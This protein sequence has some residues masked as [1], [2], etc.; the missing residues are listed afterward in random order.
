MDE[1]GKK[2][3]SSG[4]RMNR[5]NFNKFDFTVLDSILNALF[6]SRWNDVFVT[7]FSTQKKRCFLHLTWNNTRR[8]EQRATFKKSVKNG[9]YDDQAYDLYAIFPGDPWHLLLAL[10]PGRA[11]VICRIFQ[12]LRTR[13]SRGALAYVSSFFSQGKWGHADMVKKRC[14]HMCN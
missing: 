6:W 7:R 9:T 2:P 3:A 5:K 1:W 4:R 14:L 8:Q 10:E 12:E 13:W 11:R